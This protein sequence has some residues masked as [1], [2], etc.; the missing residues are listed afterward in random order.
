MSDYGDGVGVG[1]H[2]VG[3]AFVCGYICIGVV[4]VLV[5]MSVAVLCVVALL[6]V[7]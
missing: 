2:Y 3:D 7:L 6:L 5:C 4:R 1:V